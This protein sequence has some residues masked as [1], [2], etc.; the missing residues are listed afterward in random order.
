MEFKNYFKMYSYLKIIMELLNKENNIENFVISEIFNDK[1]KDINEEDIKYMYIYSALFENR[2]LKMDNESRKN[3]INI[4][5]ENYIKS[6]IVNFSN[7]NIDAAN[8]FYNMLDERVKMIS[9]YYGIYDFIDTK[10]I[11][12]I[13]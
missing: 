10:K 3:I 8:V 11:K 9:E 5:Y 1:I 13:G 4:L 2:L 12:K 7:G 6:M